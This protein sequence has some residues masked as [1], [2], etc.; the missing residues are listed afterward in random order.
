MVHLGP[1]N[2]VHLVLAPLI[3]AGDAGP[4]E[5]AVPPPSSRGGWWGGSPTGGRNAPTRAV[6]EGG[7]GQLSWTLSDLGHWGSAPTATSNF[8]RHCGEM[9]HTLNTTA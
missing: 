8:D 5:R 1:E 7:G 4:L 3:E 6:E 9:D 2:W